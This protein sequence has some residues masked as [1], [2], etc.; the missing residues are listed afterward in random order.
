MKKA[1]KKADI[2]KAMKK[3]K[4][5]KAKLKKAMK[6]KAKLKKAK[7][8]K[9]KTS[10]RVKIPSKL[11]GWDNDVYETTDDKENGNEPSIEKRFKKE[12]MM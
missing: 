4:L 1:M 5:K 10:L 11:A 9:I 8:T 3:A 12:S 6:F 2:K 7:L